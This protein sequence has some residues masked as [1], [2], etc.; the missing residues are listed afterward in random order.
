MMISLKKGMVAQHIFTMPG[1]K[2]EGH[3]DGKFITSFFTSESLLVFDISST[4]LLKSIK[5]A[6]ISASS[7]M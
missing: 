6:V 4:G 3:G 7:S 2:H 1:L 5:F